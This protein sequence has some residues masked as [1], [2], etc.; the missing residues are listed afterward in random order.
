MVTDI[1]RWLKMDIDGY[2]LTVM[3]DDGW[4]MLVSEW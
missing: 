1:H 3:V 2:K 4:F